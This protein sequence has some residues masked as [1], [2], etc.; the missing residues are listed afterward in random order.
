MTKHECPECGEVPINHRVSKF[1]YLVSAALEKLLWWGLYLET[2]AAWLLRTLGVPKLML[3]FFRF[4][5]RV[6]L[7]SIKEERDPR[8]STRTACLYDAAKA[9]GIKLYHF[10][11]LDHGD[12][13]TMV[14][15]YGNQVKVFSILP[16]PHPSPLAS[17]HW[18]DDKGRL[19]KFLLSKNIPTARGGACTTFREA[20]KHFDT[21]GAPFIVKPHIGSRGR[22]T[23]IGIQTKE[24]LEQAYFIGRELS[25]WPVVEEELQGSLYRVTLIGKKLVGVARR[26]FPGVIGDGKHTIQ[27][28]LGETNKDPRRDGFTFYPV[29]VLDRTDAQLVLQNLSWESVPQPGQRVVLNDKISRLHGATTSDVSDLV[30]RDNAELFERIAEEL[31]DPLIGIDFIMEDITRSWKEQEKLGVVECNSM[32]YIDLHQYVFEG[33]SRMLGIDLWKLFFPEA[34]TK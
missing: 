9:L 30:H 16:R 8:D 26:D 6:G 1:E 19:K 32:P 14:A 2:F 22:H 20:E 23:T 31:D 12:Y 5:E 3:P 4:L 18:I 25:F 27:E 24:A 17:Y 10:R 29:D 7:G 13:G 15:V 34:I 11:F 33:T 28:L 21:Y